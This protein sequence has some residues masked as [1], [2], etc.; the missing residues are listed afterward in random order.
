MVQRSPPRAVLYGLIWDKFLSLL[1]QKRPTLTGR[2]KRFV[3]RAIMSG[4]QLYLWALRCS[5]ALSAILIKGGTSLTSHLPK[6]KCGHA[7]AA[8]SFLI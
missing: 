1:G 6:I 3:L 2:G 4:K 8:T 7:S 5:S